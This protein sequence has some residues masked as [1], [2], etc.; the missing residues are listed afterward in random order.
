LAFQFHNADHT[1]RCPQRRKIKAWIAE[2]AKKHDRI[3][4]EISVVFCTDEYLLE[5]NR[6]HLN[7]DFYTD[8]ITFDYC[9]GLEL[10]ADLMLSIDRIKDNAKQHNQ[11]F[12]NELLRVIIHGHLH[13]V[14]YKDKTKSAQATMRL[15]ED[16][17]IANYHTM[18]HD[19]SDL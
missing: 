5:V 19:P 16:E 9:E 14:G 7:H 18:F 13:L 1:F 15:K 2:F 11:L 12:F 10:N 6:T 4:G 3:I 8:I 17:W